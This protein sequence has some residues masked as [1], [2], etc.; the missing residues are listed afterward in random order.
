VAS[1][2]GSQLA[3]EIMASDLPPGGYLDVDDVVLHLWPSN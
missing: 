3:L 1:R 2:S